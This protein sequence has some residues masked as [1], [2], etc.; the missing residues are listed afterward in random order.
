MI[1]IQLSCFMFGYSIALAVLFNMVA[2]VVVLVLCLCVLDRFCCFFFSIELAWLFYFDQLLIFWTKW[3]MFDC[4]SPSLF[5]NGRFWKNIVIKFCWNYRFI[6]PMFV[7][8][9]LSRKLLLPFQ[10]VINSS[11]LIGWLVH[12]YFISISR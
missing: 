4:F 2:A 8:L 11:W 1:S 5:F 7:C 6:F 10:I 9:L 12:Y 3:H